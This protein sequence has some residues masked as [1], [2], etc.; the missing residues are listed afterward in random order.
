M[1]YK[2]IDIAETFNVLDEQWQ[3][4]VI[5]EVKVMLIEPRGVRNIGKQGGKRTAK[6][7]VWI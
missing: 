1:Q 7:D 5:A 2:P 6:N 4:R 3:H